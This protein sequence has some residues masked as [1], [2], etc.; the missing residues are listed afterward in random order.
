[1]IDVH[2]HM[3][4]MPAE[5]VIAEARKKMTAIITSVADPKEAEKILQLSE[6][7]RDFLYVSLGFHPH[8]VKDYSDEQ[9]NEYMEFIRANQN[10]IVAIGEVGLDYSEEYDDRMKKVFSQF[11]ELAKELTLPLVVHTRN[12][13]ENTNAFSDVLDILEKQNAENVVLHCF[14]GSD[15]NL[16]KALSRDY[17][18]SFATIICK[19][20]KH[21]RLVSETPLEKMLLETD[22]PW[23]DP[24]SNE[25]KNRPWN[26]IES[27]KIIA[28]IKGVSVEEV[29]AATTRNAK[30]AFSIPNKR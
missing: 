1:M 13:I 25:R 30:K 9:I 2:C 4:H 17:W 15:G 20:K 19:T 22:A 18:I 21:P 24:F 6:K 12:G 7:H 14:S 26:I 11:I 29:L 16:K 28:D 23:L 5:E 3:E 27:A 10:R 8:C